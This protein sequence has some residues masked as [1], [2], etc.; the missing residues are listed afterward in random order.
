MWGRDGHAAA[1]G[2]HLAVF[3]AL[4]QRAGAPGMRGA[5]AWRRG[6]GRCNSGLLGR[7][8]KRSRGRIRVVAVVHVCLARTIPDDSVC[9]MQ[10]GAVGFNEEREQVW[11]LATKP[12]CALFPI[13]QLGLSFESWLQHLRKGLAV[14]PWL[15]YGRRHAAC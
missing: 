15:G 12:L 11:V 1:A 14:R 4:S 9:G 7:A 13:A 2:V 8:N 10:L 6:R 5:W 3:L